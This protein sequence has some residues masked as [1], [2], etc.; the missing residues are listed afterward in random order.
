MPESD[1]QLL[2][3]IFE[4]L[5]AVVNDPSANPYTDDG[6]YAAAIQTLQP[7]LRA[8][9]ATHHL[10]ISLTLDDIGWH[11]LNFEDPSLMV[12][13]EAGLRLLGLDD[14]AQ[15]F[16]EAAMIMVSL[17]S[18]ITGDNYEECLEKHG[19]LQRMRELQSNADSLE[20]K[21]SGSQIYAAWVKYA[22]Q[23]PEEGF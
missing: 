15:W 4:R 9:A 17:K 13:T 14:L 19:K 20:P 5:N 8:M 6:S 16:R 3:R 2:E 23:H 21:L 12:E 1:E 11:F 7:G 22:R 10:D 18:E